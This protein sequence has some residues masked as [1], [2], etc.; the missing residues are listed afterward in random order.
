MNLMILLLVAA[1]VFQIGLFLYSRKVKKKIKANDILHKYQINSRS[2][3][4][5][6]LS[7][8]DLPEED[9]IKLQTIYDDNGE[10]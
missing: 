10:V 5:A 1:L 3:L 6:V 7:S 2:D 4:F 8:N 9:A